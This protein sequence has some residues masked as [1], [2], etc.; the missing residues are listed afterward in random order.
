MSGTVFKDRKK[1]T[2]SDSAATADPDE[3]ESESETS[4]W[5]SDIDDSSKDSSDSDGFCLRRPFLDFESFEY[6]VEVDEDEGPDLVNF[7]VQIRKP[8]K[9]NKS[10]ADRLHLAVWENKPEIVQFLIFKEGM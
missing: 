6:D 4:P 3:G 9:R 2:W 5:S 7:P 1:V 10:P 8:R